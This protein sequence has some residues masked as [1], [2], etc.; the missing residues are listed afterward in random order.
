[1]VARSHKKKALGHGISSDM[2]DFGISTNLLPPLMVVD[3]AMLVLGLGIH[4]P[5]Q[6]RG[7]RGSI[8]KAHCTFRESNP[9]PSFLLWE[10]ATIL[11]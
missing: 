2:T 4:W 8:R 7:D 11:P 9:R 6:E 3:A 5:H 10:R 1:M